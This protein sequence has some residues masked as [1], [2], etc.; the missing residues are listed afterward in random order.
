M[1]KS[2]SNPSPVPAARVMILSDAVPQRNGVGTYYHDLMEYLQ[3]E[4]GHVEMIPARANC[5]FKKNKVSIPLPGDHSQNLYLPNVLPILRQIQKEKPDL[6]IAPTLG[7]FALLARLVSRF[8]RRPLI[9]GYHTSLNKLAHLYWQGGFGDLSA[10]YL[11]RASRVMFRQAD[12]VVVNTEAMRQEAL[13]LGARSVHVMGTTIARPLTLQ[14]LSPF[15]GHIRTVLFGGR[16]AKEKR[17]M[18]VAEAAAELPELQFRIAGDGPLMGE[19]Q[20]FASST[21]NLTLTGWL[22][23]EKL[24][25]EID[26][27]DLVVLPSAHESFGSIALEVMARGRLMLVSEHCGIL[28]WPE[29]AEGLC[30]IREGETVADAVRRLQ[31]MPPE[32]AVDLARR[33]K[34]ATLNM[35][36]QTLRGWKQLIG[37]VC[38]A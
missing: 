37:E 1:M 33:A 15:D 22:S 32:E 21:S 18:R 24:L 30:V 5:I 19:L 8:T 13:S 28:Q 20:A 29:L 10:W 38:A 17:V 4:L 3:A 7:P 9:F 34:Q 35:N 11:K 6:L 27:A 26:R 25:Q 16:L 12:R 14:P 2:S 36:E 23:R 31:K